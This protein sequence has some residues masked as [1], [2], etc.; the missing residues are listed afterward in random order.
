MEAERTGM[1]DVTYIDFNS[2]AWHEACHAAGF[3]AQ[4]HVP[5]EA[6]CDW[7]RDVKLEDGTRAIIYGLVKPD[8]SREDEPGFARTYAIACLAG[9]SDRP[10]V[11]PKRNGIHGDE[12]LLALLIE[13]NG[14]DDTESFLKLRFEAQ[15]LCDTRRFKHLA[16]AVYKR[17]VE[18]EVLDQADLREIYEQ[19]QERAGCPEE[20]TA[21]TD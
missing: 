8:F 16:V 14:W 7:P 9:M 21:C 15:D 13:D 2:T 5:L 6:R 3:M 10:V 18:V 1:G 12:N 19:E 17:L 4:D 20:K 11:A